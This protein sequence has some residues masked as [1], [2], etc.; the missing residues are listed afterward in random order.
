MPNITEIVVAIEASG[1]EG[2]LAALKQVDGAQTT[3]AN[4]TTQLGKGTS[5]AASE[6]GNALVQFGQ[7]WQGAV[8]AV[9]TAALP[10]MA[11]TK[12]VKAGIEFTQEGASLDFAATKFDNLAGSIGATGSVLLRDLR[13]A[14]RGVKSDF[15]LMGLASNLMAMRL[16]KTPEDVVRLTAVA[17]A[18]NMD[19]SQLTM[20]LTNMSKLRLDQLGLSVEGV[21]SRFE[22]LKKSGTMT[23]QEAWFQAVVGAGEEAIG[24]MGHV[25]DT[26][27]GAWAR[28]SANQKTYWDNAKKNTSAVGV[29]W[30]D[31]WGKVYGDK[32]QL[33]EAK[34]SFQD[35]L[36]AGALAPEIVAKY[37]KELAQY[38]VES[39]ITGMNEDFTA[40]FLR[41][42]E[43]Q[44]KNAQAT[45]ERIQGSY[46]WRG[47]AEGAGGM[48]GLISG[49]FDTKQ[50]QD[51]KLD[52]IT[53]QSL[54]KVA[55]MRAGYAAIGA[56]WESMAKMAIKY[57]EVLYDITANNK[58]LAE[59]QAIVDGTSDSFY[60]Q[61]MSV[62][63]AKQAIEGL[64][65]TNN[66]LEKAMAQVAA[67]MTLSMMQASMEIGGYT[68]SEIAALT[69]YMVDAGMITQAAA[70]KM[71]I[72]F[73]AAMNLANSLELE[74]KIGEI[75]ADT[76]K[77]ENG[78]AIVDNM[79]IDAKTGE[80]L[81]DITK[82]LAG[83]S[84][85]DLAKLDP[86]IVEIL[87]AIGPY[88]DALLALPDPEDK[89]VDVSLNYKDPGHVPDVP[90]SVDVW[91]NYTGGTAFQTAIGGP[92]Y[93]GQTRTWNEPG[94]EGEMLIPSQYGRVLSNHEVAQ[95]IRE[96]LQPEAGGSTKQNA[97]QTQKNI[98]VTV[99]AAVANDYDLDKLTREIVRRINA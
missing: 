95:V 73:T 31:F 9:T 37:N 29:V 28:M 8:A 58:D 77:Y 14:S 84:E 65:E 76:T 79:L 88:L 2:V 75:L 63:E 38:A 56:D 82:Y 35:L 26:D 72:D 62:E 78:L 13:A 55:E 89:E 40:M 85:A 7:K 69:Q 20:T 66:G 54:A 49:N 67:N 86:R 44:I 3:M 21:T 11:V 81:A 97:P 34:N 6:G 90:Q 32:N 46:A 94:R 41:E 36:K 48:S 43:Q 25:A 16:A 4:K 93:P 70:D 23:D 12:A 1:V 19:M 17:G 64:T 74:A 71:A 61:A 5:Q 22:E 39:Q 52:L 45:W 47:I 18:M 57:D 83:M 53:N 51:L 68:E 60:G 42:N 91:V 50:F 27:A 59:L 24:I 98:S 87:A 15:E 92:V 33:N 10:I 99:N 96:S 30:A 80:I